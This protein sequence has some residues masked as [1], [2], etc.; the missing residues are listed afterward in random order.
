MQKIIKYG[1]ILSILHLIIFTMPIYIYNIPGKYG[2]ILL[3]PTLLIYVYEAP[4]FFINKI[5]SIPVDYNNI[6]FVL[7]NC[8]LGALL[9]F[10]IGVFIIYIRSRIKRI[11]G[12]FLFLLV[13][14]VL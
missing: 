10:I 8:I 13:Y 11:K 6:R 5:L 12:T 1:I 3:L 2:G 9:Y 7:F 14:F 4:I